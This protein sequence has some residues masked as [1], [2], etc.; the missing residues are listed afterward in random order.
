MLDNAHLISQRDPQDALG[1]AATQPAQLAHSFDVARP[2]AHGPVRSLVFAGMGG[3]ALMAE[4][5][6]TYPALKLPFVISKDYRLPDFVDASTLVICAS[7]SGNTEETLS[8][9][10][11][12][13]DKGAM[14]VTM[15]HGGKL[16]EAAE[17]ER[18]LHIEIPHCPQPRTAVFYGYRATCEVLV[19][20][21]LAEASLLDELDRLVPELEAHMTNWLPGVPETQNLAKQLAGSMV[22][23]T[24]IIYAGPLMAPAAY[25]WKIDVNENAKNTAWCGVLPEFN[26]NEFLGWSSHPVEKPFAVIDLL[27]RF[28]HPRV[29]KRFEV[30]DR[31]LSGLRPKSTMLH[32]EGGSV[33][34]HL[35]YHVLLGDFATTYLAI[36][37]GVNPT[38]VALVEK[39]KKELDA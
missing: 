31:M 2:A 35:L 16:A 18:V 26:H 19:A 15:S 38:P 29:L 20:Y 32:A 28:E 3:S 21:G 36:L 27:S 37:N 5:L 4:F 14:A 33:L 7:Y 12:A 8:A 30:S 11:D 1:F 17:H 23:K 24:P 34:E 10:D 22:G 13:L 9:L 25:K 39:F 6:R